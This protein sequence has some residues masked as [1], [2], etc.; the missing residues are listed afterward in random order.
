M[1]S[2]EKKTST[3]QKNGMNLVSLHGIIR[4]P[5]SRLSNT[6]AMRAASS[7]QSLQ[8]NVWNAQTWLVGQCY[9]MP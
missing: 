5:F 8:M 2:L 4:S 9:G 6:F 7:M 3:I 1:S